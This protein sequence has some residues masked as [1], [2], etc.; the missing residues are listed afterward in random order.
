MSVE[1]AHH[2]KVVKREE[3][4]ETTSDLWVFGR[5]GGV[6]SRGGIY[7]LAIWSCFLVERRILNTWI[8]MFDLELV[9]GLGVWTSVNIMSCR[10][11]VRSPPPLS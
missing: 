7:R 11:K 4:G 6:G 2:Y 3:K 1:I 10:M 8:S 9:I 5:A